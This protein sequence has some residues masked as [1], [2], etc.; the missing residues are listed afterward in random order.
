M[1]RE[2][3]EKPVKSVPEPNH[4]AN[5]PVWAC[6]EPQN[7]F[8]G[9]LEKRLLR[10]EEELHR[11]DDYDHSAPLLELISGFEQSLQ[12]AGDNSTS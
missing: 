11:S 7:R 12:V 9:P 2:G 8:Q 6:A 1:E 3:A 10:L 4:I 5:V